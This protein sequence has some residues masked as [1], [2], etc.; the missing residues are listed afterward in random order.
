MITMGSTPF[1][2]A[3]GAAIH[4][5]RAVHF[6]AAA[7]R[8]VGSHPGKLLYCLQPFSLRLCFIAAAPSSAQ[9]ALLPELVLGGKALRLF[10]DRAKDMRRNRLHSRDALKFVHFSKAC[11]DPLHLLER[12][13]PLL[14]RVIELTV[15]PP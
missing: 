5:K 10:N 9:L 11:A 6:A 8:L 1:L 3:P 7:K 12:F 13:L 4:A 15:D 14:N 2:I